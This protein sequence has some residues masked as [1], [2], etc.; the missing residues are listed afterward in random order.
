MALENVIGQKEIDL[1]DKIATYICN[2][3]VSFFSFFFLSFFSLQERKIISF[4]FLFLFCFCF[5]FS[6]SLFSLSQNRVDMGEDVDHTVCRGMVDEFTPQVFY[7]FFQSYLG[8]T[9]YFLLYLF[10][11]LLSRIF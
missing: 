6:F 2:H 8:F 5:L 7:I 1:V 11:F 4:I 9:F 3:L 10:S